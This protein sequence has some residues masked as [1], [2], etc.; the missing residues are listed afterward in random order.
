MMLESNQE[1]VSSFRRQRNQAYIFAALTFLVS[2]AAVANTFLG[3]RQELV[4][5]STELINTQQALSNTQ[6]ALRE[7]QDAL[8]KLQKH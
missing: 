7:T 6:K 2:L 1:V 5:V 3:H 4:N 8:S